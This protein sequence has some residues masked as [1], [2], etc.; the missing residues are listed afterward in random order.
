MTGGADADFVSA[1]IN[2]EKDDGAK[3]GTAMVVLD[4]ADEGPEIEREFT[5]LDGSDHVA[6]L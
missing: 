3:L 5:S 4:M 6:T 2:V 1:L